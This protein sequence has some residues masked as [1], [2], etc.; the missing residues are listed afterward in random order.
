M[1]TS[2][3]MIL[4][5]TSREVMINEGKHQLH[6]MIRSETGNNVYDTCYINRVLLITISSTLSFKLHEDDGSEEPEPWNESEILHSYVWT[7]HRTINLPIIPSIWSENR[8][9]FLHW[10][11]IIYSLRPPSTNTSSLC[12]LFHDFYLHPDC[13]PSGFRLKTLSCGSISSDHLL[14]C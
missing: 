10:S 13:R 5:F 8:F 3:W 11:F 9:S 12:F 6:V 4:V 1:F 2:S 14:I 7:Q